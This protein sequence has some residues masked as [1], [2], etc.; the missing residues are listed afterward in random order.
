MNEWIP[1][2]DRLPEESGDI[3]ATIADF[4]CWDDDTEE[5]I[6]GDECKSLK[7]YSAHFERFKMPYTNGWEW[8]LSWCGYDEIGESVMHVLR[9]RYGTRWIAWMPYPDPYKGSEGEE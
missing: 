5:L 2:S 9:N 1:C 4:S 7:T 3:L 6:D 8:S